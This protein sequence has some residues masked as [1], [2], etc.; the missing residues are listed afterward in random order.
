MFSMMS[1]LVYM[2]MQIV[3][4]ILAM[5]P[6]SMLFEEGIGF[7]NQ[8]I[9]LGGMASLDCMYIDWKMVIRDG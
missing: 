5:L 7:L 2:L 9:G 6:S 4:E 3:G 8:P 1:N